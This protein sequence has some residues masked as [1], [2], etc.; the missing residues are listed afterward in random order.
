MRFGVPTAIVDGKKLANK[1]VIRREE[2]L[3]DCLV[4]K[5]EVRPYITIPRI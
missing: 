2:D 5:E 1:R 3:L 4:N